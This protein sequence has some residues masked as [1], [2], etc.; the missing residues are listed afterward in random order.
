[1]SKIFLISIMLFL[2]INVLVFGQANTTATISGFI[3]DYEGNSLQRATIKVEHI[4]TGTKSGAYS[5]TTGKY[6]ILGLKVGG[7][8]KLTVSMVGFEPQEFNDIYLSLN[9]TFS[10]NF[11]MNKSEKT[12]AEVV[13]IGDKNDIISNQRTGAS[14]KVS[15]TDIQNLPTIARS[16][17][18]YTRLSPLII[19]STSDGSNVAGRNSK[20]NNIAVDGAVMGDAFGL[21]ASGTPGGGAG[22]QP[23]SLDAIEQFQVSISPFDVREGGFT[24]G[25]INAITKNGTNKYNGTAYLYGRN[26]NFVGNSPVNDAAYPNFKEYQ[27]G[28]STG[29]PIIKDKLFYFAN[30]E[31]RK[32]NDPTVLG[33]RG[34]SE[35]NVFD[36]SAD[37]LEL[38]RQTAISKF[39]YEPGSFKNYERETKDYKLF[40][41][42]DYNLNDNN[43][44]TL[45]HNYVNA[46]QGN[47]VTRSKTNLSYSN[48]EYLFRSVQN[49][50]V[51]QLNSVLAENMANEL[52]ISY[53]S[54]RD[55][56]DPV[57]SAF[58]SITITQLGADKKEAVSFG[59]ERFSQANSLDQDILEFTDNFN[60]FLGDHVIT[61]G[62]SNQYVKFNNV[63][64]QDFYGTWEFEGVENFINSKASKY[65]LTYANTAATGG[66]KKPTAELSYMQWGF[67]AQDDWSVMENFKLTI[68]ARVDMYSYSSDPL[69][70]ANFA[71]PHSWY[72]FDSPTVLST[73]KMPSPMAVSPRLGFNWDIDNNK[74]MQLRGGI[75]LFSGRTPG[76]W[77]GNQYANTGADL[78]R[79]SYTNPNYQFTTDVNNQPRPDS[80]G[81]QTSEVDIT[82]KDFKMPQVLRANI[83]FDYQLPMGFIASF[84]FLY[85]KSINDVDYQN[86]NLKYATNVDG[87]IKYAPD[88]R[89]LYMGDKST[90]V[91]DSAYTSVIYMKNTDKGSQLNLI[92]QLQKPY[93]QGILPNLSANISYT[94]SRVQDIN[95]L[96]SSRAISNWQYNVGVD[97]NKSELTTS[98]YEIPHKIMM[99]LS[100]TYDYFVNFPT[101]IGLYYE[102]RSGQAFSM[103]YYKGTINKD[104]VQNSKVVDANNDNILGNDL[105]YI[106]KGENDPN[107]ILT[108]NNWSELNSFINEFDEL[109]NNR[110]KIME[111]NSLRQPWR[112]QFDMRIAQDFKLG[113]KKL[114]I[115]LDILNVLN[116]INKDWGQVKYIANGSYSLLAFEGYD[117]TTGAMR[118]SYKPNSKGNSAD[119]IYSIDDLAS[120]WQLQLGLRF[121]F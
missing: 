46:D 40:L 25:L 107:F 110:G 43:R 95:S 114:Q 39:G 105:I 34:S 14:Q 76:V 112:N 88:G 109:K 27:L 11:K 41:R 23:I 44:I 90:N 79:L 106:P 38:I 50:T 3:K 8:Y 36:V 71:T 61:I 57:S 17:Q 51:L 68:G 64:L 91:V 9:Q 31:T 49:Q 86:I 52:K 45:R 77:I 81:S 15:N 121:S 102:G 100:Y 65:Y 6:T 4:P 66:N 117:K 48:Q 78:Y 55:K 74:E 24:G 59:V 82:D 98:Y 29:G 80:P 47:A 118:A 26:Q 56:R 72:G 92:A 35:A 63:F 111:K 67:Y 37:T 30:L 73:S 5:S 12:T 99:N 54:I 115:T 113:D 89:P 60:Y 104:L 32:R 69:F 103:V 16:L 96:T 53:T 70:N 7:P 20:Y 119:N 108:S 120:R 101:T 22:T 1:M 94:F 2:G 116:L 62:T 33:L 83:G 58:P 18:D 84:E 87:S 10:A 97:P 85:G 21:A 75:G 28:A 93:G 19:S 13:I 42:F